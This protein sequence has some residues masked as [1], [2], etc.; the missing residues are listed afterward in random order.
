M[1]NSELIGSAAGRRIF[2]RQDGSYFVEAIPRDECDRPMSGGYIEDLTSEQ[3]LGYLEHD[4]PKAKVADD[5]DR[6]YKLTSPSTGGS[7]EWRAEQ[8]ARMIAD[9]KRQK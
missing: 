7:R 2:R 1:T 3:V 9:V 8:I 6:F 5:N 4:L